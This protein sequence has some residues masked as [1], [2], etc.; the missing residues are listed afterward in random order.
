MV[1]SLISAMADNG[2]IGI[3]NRLPW[4][5]P[6]DMRWFRKH[7]LG[8][9]IIMGRLTF[10]SFGGKPLPDRTNIV[11]THD[12]DYRAAGAIVVDSID[13][14]IQ[15][16]GD[17]EEVMIIGGA[18]FYQQLLP[19]A[20]RM[21]LT[22]IHAVFEGDAYFPEFSKDQWQQTERTDCAPDDKNP[23]HYSFTVWQKKPS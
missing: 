14:A 15:Q 11:V 17:C 5:L 9:P 4:K 8:K 3:D 23:Y 2:V 7:T 19:R 21:Y 1:I 12:R 20:Q 22:F 18:S 10:E 13:K 6:A 16:A